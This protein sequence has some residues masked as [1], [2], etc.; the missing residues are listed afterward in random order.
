MI[1]NLALAALVATTLG[2]AAQAAEPGPRL[3]NRSDV[4]ADFYQGR[5][6]LVGGAI[7]NPDGSV[8]YRA[9][10]AHRALGQ[11][12]TALQDLPQSW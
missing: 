12:G 9:Q 7:R 6:N 3:V 11:P 5:D 8:T 2:A 1:R 4:T 10:G